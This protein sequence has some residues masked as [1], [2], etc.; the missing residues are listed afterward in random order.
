MPLNADINV[1][2]SAKLTKALNDRTP[3]EI[4]TIEKALKLLDGSLAGQATQIFTDKRVLAASANETLDLNGSTLKNVFGDNFSLTRVVALVII[5]EAGNTNDVLFGP[6]ASNGFVT[7]FNAAADRLKVKP[8]GWVALVAPDANGYAVVA[9][10][11]DGLFVANAA[12]GSS[13]TYTVVVIG[14]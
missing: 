13:V 12:G 4:R 8:N 11:G 2:V 1:R 3:E 10:T 5:A 9:G 6:A 14:S 7:P